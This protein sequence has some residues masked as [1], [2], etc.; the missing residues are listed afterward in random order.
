MKFRLL[1]S[2]SIC[3]V[4]VSCT[5]ERIS[6]D[7]PGKN[8]G[9]ITTNVYHDLTINADS[10]Q[11]LSTKTSLGEG[12]SVLW[13]E[14]DSFNLVGQAKETP[15]VDVTYTVTT[16]YETY[17]SYSLSNA[18]DGDESTYF[19]SSEAQATGKYILISFNTAVKLTSFSTY[20][21]NSSD[22]P[23]TGQYLQVSADETEW[24]DIG[25]F[26]G[27]ATCSF[28]NIESG[29]IK[30]VRIYAK[31]DAT[32]WLV[33]NEI[34]MTA[35]A[36]PS[37]VVI[38]VNEKFTIESG[39]GEASATF[40]GTV[41]GDI[42]GQ[43]LYAFYPYSTDVVYDGTNVSFDMPY[44]QTY[45]PDGFASGANPMI[46]I[47]QEGDVNFKNLCGVLKLAIKGTQLVRSISITDSAGSPLWGGVSFPVANIGQAAEVSGGS[48]TVLLNCGD[49]VQLNE[50][51]P[52]S[53]C[54]VVPAGV[55]SEGFSAKITTS[56][57]V[58]EISTSKP[59]TISRSTARVMPPFV[60]NIVSPDVLWEQG[61]EYEIAEATFSSQST[62][63]E[64]MMVKNAM[65][66]NDASLENKAV[67]VS[68]GTTLTLGANASLSNTLII[69][70]LG[71]ANLDAG[72]VSASG[73]VAMKGMRAS[74]GFLLKASSLGKLYVD[75]CDFGFASSGQSLLDMASNGGSQMTELSVVGNVFHSS[76]A[77]V[78]RTI[79]L[80][81]NSAG[82]NFGTLKVNDNM[83][84]NIKGDD[85]A[86]VSV[87]GVGCLAL[88]RNH[89]YYGNS[90]ADDFAI[91][92]SSSAP[93]ES[94]VASNSYYAAEGA[95]VVSSYGTAHAHSLYT[96]PLTSADIQNGSY[97]YGS[98]LATAFY[99]LEGK[100]KQCAV[101]R[102]GKTVSLRHSP[103]ETDVDICVMPSVDYSLTGTWPSKSLTMSY[104]GSY[105]TYS[106]ILPDYVSTSSI[107]TLNTDDGGWK[108]VWADEFSGDD[109]DREVWTRCPKDTP[110]WA[111]EQYPE[112]E[113]LVQVSDGALIT[114][115]RKESD[116]TIGNGGYV[117]GGIW[118]EN[119][120]SFNL[121]M[122][123]VTG[124]IDVRAR[125]TDAKGYWPAIW[126]MPQQDSFVWPQWG[127]IDIMEHLNYGS[128]YWATLHTS[129]SY[130]DTGSDNS[131][132]N[133]GSTSF[134]NRTS[135][136]VFSVIVIN[137]E[138]RLLLDG[139]TSH[140]CKKSDHADTSETSIDYWLNYWPFDQTEYYLILDS[141][142]NGSWPGSAD[143]TDLPAHMDIDYVRY[144]VKE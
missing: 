77:S 22:M 137:D 86:I 28:E 90:L 6:P 16:N 3:A 105:D 94:T 84:M 35:V 129:R 134:T 38:P 127:E 111:K 41:E 8:T 93:S 44:E 18:Y 116:T 142:L 27:E 104:N 9:T 120:K 31:S 46:G 58:A 45:S 53:F 106:V 26:N 144:F 39:V 109:W 132:N 131:C 15:T 143:G 98:P 21:S 69:C 40:T 49:G 133:N 123:G 135:W 96:D 115:G 66:V 14:G 75:S 97:T 136:H 100:T 82:V 85:G 29:A 81:G 48:S 50:S 128:T 119:L 61:K 74:S 72:A 103:V 89:F 5:H 79:S 99:S 47:Y 73:L 92:K 87:G 78:Q 37:E 52:T 34:T 1:S 101:D 20:S 43:T 130:G 2:I 32:N 57:G 65:T 56:E 64:A 80:A 114:W 108:S 24:T 91:L 62:G 67:F 13:S 113:T 83:F 110:D 10:E 112:D 36:Q 33:L 95:G 118:G 122:N 139:V 117:C 107:Q 63:L 124:R 19:W 23:K 102:N 17:Q 126:M 25:A 88:E 51:E 68:G 70:D 138:I 55:F 4:L 54:L 60:L 7:D 71:Q 121:G 30:Y 59:N 140:T 141:Q 11:P 125:M 12:Y 76:D 42:S